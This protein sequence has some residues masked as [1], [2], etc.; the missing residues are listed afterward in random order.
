SEKISENDY[1]YHL[2]VLDVRKSGKTSFKSNLSK[3]IHQLFPGRIVV[4]LFDPLNNT[5][6]KITLN[7]LTDYFLLHGLRLRDKITVQH[8]PENHWEVITQYGSKVVFH[9]C[10]YEVLIF[11]KGKFN[12]KS[13]TEEEKQACLIDKGQFQ[14]EK[15]FLS[16]WDFRKH[17]RKVSDPVVTTRILELFLYNEEI[18]CSN[19]RQLTCPKRSFS[20]KYHRLS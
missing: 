17:P 7:Q 11:Q 3:V 8:Q 12:Y 6:N 4:A 1:R 10:Y 20:L 19:I 15:W 18:V 14:R 2:L 9:H 16:L 13:K 5:G